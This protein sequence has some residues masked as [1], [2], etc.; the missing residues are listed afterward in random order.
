MLLQGII[1]AEILSCL[2]GFTICLRKAITVRKKPTASEINA[3]MCG[4]IIYF[5]TVKLVWNDTKIY[6]KLIIMKKLALE[7][8]MFL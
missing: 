5:C 3:K 8:G 4:T 2:S 7:F 1:Q 6:I